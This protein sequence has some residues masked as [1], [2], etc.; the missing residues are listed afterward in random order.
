[1]G[2][3]DSL[4][5]KT[6][7][8]TASKNQAPAAAP[9]AQ[10]AFNSL[11][12]P[13]ST[14]PLLHA[15]APAPAAAP[16][17]TTPVAVNADN[18][19]TAGLTPA[20]AKVA[21][22]DDINKKN[23]EMKDNNSVGGFVKNFFQSAGTQISDL[24][25]SAVKSTADI[26]GGMESGGD[27]ILNGAD[28][29]AD[30]VTGQQYT[31]NDPVI[32]DF[33]DS[34]YN[35]LESDLG[36][37]TQSFDHTVMS[38][39]GE[40]VPWIIGG[41]VVKG[42]TAAGRIG[43][44]VGNLGFSAV[45]GLMAASTDYKASKDAGD[46]TDTAALKAVGVFAATMGVNALTHSLSGI[47]GSTESAATPSLTQSLGNWLKSGIIETA[48]MGGAQTIISNVSQ[49]R[50]PLE[51][52][53]T[54]LLSAAPGMFAFAALG[55]AGNR[56]TAAATEAKTKEFLQIHADNGIT[57][58]TAVKS[59]QNLTG[60]NDPKAVSYIN[61]LI[62][63][64]P[65]MATK[66]DDNK[67][68]QDKA[69]ADENAQTA[70][71]HLSS[72]KTPDQAVLHMSQTM[73]VGDAQ[74]AVADAQTLQEAENPTDEPVPPTQQ[75]APA[76][77]E[78]AAP[79]AQPATPADISINSKPAEVQD[80]FTKATSDFGDS[81]KDLKSKAFD[82]Q[83]AVDSAEKGSNEKKQAKV[84]LEKTRKQLKKAASDH[85][86]KMVGKVKELHA[87][88]E[89]YANKNHN[90]EKIPK[91]DMK[92]LVAQ[93]M[94][95][96]TDPAHREVFKNTKV[97]D[98]A[99]GV[100]SDYAKAH[101][102]EGSEAEKPTKG[103][104]SSVSKTEKQPTSKKSSKDEVGQ[105]LDAVK[106]DIKARYN[107][108]TKNGS[109]SAREQAGRE[110]KGD[111]MALASTERKIRGNTTGREQENA[112]KYL[113][114]NHTGKEVY[115]NDQK[116]KTTGKVSFGRHEVQ[117]E[118]GTKKFIP[119]GEIEGDKI[120]KQAIA[121]HLKNE[122]MKELAGQE[123][124]RRIKTPDSS[125]SAAKVEDKKTVENKGQK[126]QSSNSSKK[127]ED[128]QPIVKPLS[129]EKKAIDNKKE[130]DAEAA[131][132][133]AVPDEKISTTQGRKAA[134]QKP[135]A[136]E[137]EKVDSRSAVLSKIADQIGDDAAADL[138][139]KTQHNVVNA[140]KDAIKSLDFVEQYPDRA[141]RIVKGLEN[142]PEGI[143]TTNI[144]YAVAQ[145]AL[146]EGD[147]ETATRALESD[148]L[149]GTRNAQE[150]ALRRGRTNPNDPA[151]WLQKAMASRMDEA[152]KESII[153]DV[154]KKGA[155][156]LDKSEGE[157]R[158]KIMNES[159]K[160]KRVVSKA[161]LKIDDMQKLVDSITC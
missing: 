18:F 42:L 27:L 128:K 85:D 157:P 89:D 46:D 87:A 93:T 144:K 135:I 146:S 52:V 148:I 45:Q 122:G 35:K 61:N 39:V 149:G 10:T 115:V 75:A 69:A 36:V 17:S 47:L 129:T 150:L 110:S 4:A 151:T 160:M 66:F 91:E 125:K 132:K 82:Q 138:K 58:D 7:A 102:G 78:D 109:A 62:A 28:M 44:L 154:I 108:R 96:A 50:A 123:M 130:T 60:N 101:A 9:S 120:T 21:I 22:Q 23:Q 86:T 73:S 76:P 107:D 142:P 98:I 80:H 136:S 14:I 6:V 121:D 92:D 117:F 51:G 84:D 153:Y 63:K 37:D 19:S 77:A 12:A 147:V 2:V 41:E 81:V 88:I 67:A 43:A 74:K 141:D 55:E 15:D 118:D 20:Q 113:E 1:M 34:T 83:S 30:K 8:P 29:L 145:K 119:G 140:K 139:N 126:E 79:E 116:G 134:I 68:K 131:R 97:S 95:F 112:R 31:A 100:F 159:D 24:S 155:G 32:T 16:A 72:G 65:E 71:G 11:A 13:G 161:Q 111:S 3:F 106:A 90:G 158:S 59:Y 156:K 143:S 26:L 25:I 137:G 38:S 5:A 133:L 124:T 57:K 103:K 70:A 104:D 53:G 99:R 105:R 54:S 56:D 40:A 152:N 48:N 49:G 127:T 33:A 94:K 114:S 64:D